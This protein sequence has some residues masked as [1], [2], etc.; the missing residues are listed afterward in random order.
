MRLTIVISAAPGQRELDGDRPRR[1][2]RAEHNDP[3]SG[4]IGHGAER[5]EKPAAVGVV[6]DQPPAVVLDAVDRLDQTGRVRQLV[7]V[8]DHRHLV[9]HRDVAT[10][11]THGTSTAN[12]VAQPLG[13]DFQREISPVEAGR[14][15]R[16]FHD[17][18]RRVAGHRL[19]KDERDG[20]EWVG[21]AEGSGFG[22]QGSARI[23]NAQ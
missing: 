4:R 9:R 13:R 14:R 1:T 6:A 22:V 18:L 16:S 21:Q 12:R 10:L 2:P 19:A 23:R 11:K 8:L 7:Q 15:E 3:L 17:E 20:L 5:F